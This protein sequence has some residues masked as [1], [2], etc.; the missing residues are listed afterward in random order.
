MANHEDQSQDS[1]NLSW[2]HSV[3]YHVDIDEPDANSP[4]GDHAAESPETS[5]QEPATTYNGVPRNVL[6]NAQPLLEDEIRLL[7]LEKGTHEIPLTGSLRIV[8]L[9]DYPEYE[10]LS[11]TWEDFDAVQPSE[12]NIQDEVHPALFLANTASYLDLTPNCAKALYSVRKTTAD[13]TIWVDSI[14][15]NQDDPEERSRQVDLMNEIYARAFKVLVYLGRDTNEDQSSSSIAMKLLSQPDRLQ[16]FDQLQQRETTSLKRLFER[17]YFRRMWIVQEVTLAKTL[18]LHCGRDTSYVSKFA[19][20]PLETILGSRVTPPWLRHSKQTASQPRKRQEMSQAEQIFGLI[21]DTSQCDCKDDRD[22]IFALFSLLNAKDEERLKADYNLSTTQVYSGLAAYLATSG[23]LWAMLMLAPRLA[24]N[25]CPG[26]PSWVPDWSSLGNYGQQAPSLLKSIVSSSLSLG[27]ETM[28]RIHNSGIIAVS[29]IHLGS[30]TYTGHSCDYPFQTAAMNEN[31]RLTTGLFAKKRG[32]DGSKKSQGHVSIWTLANLDRKK[33]LDSW[34][35]H[36]NFVTRCEQPRETQHLAFMLLDYSTVLILRYHNRF[37]DPYTLVEAGKPLIGVVP[38]QGWKGPFETSPRFDLQLL[39]R[40]TRGYDPWDT[41]FWLQEKWPGLSRFPQLWS[42]DP[43]ATSAKL[44]LR[45]IQEIRQIDM[46]E[47]YLLHRWQEHSHTVIGILKDQARLR[48]LIEQVIS[49]RDE[50]YAQREV[51]A[52]LDQGWSLYHFLG[53]FV[54]E[55]SKGENM[56]WH[57]MQLQGALSPDDFDLLSQVM[58]WAKVTRQVLR[59]LSREQRTVSHWSELL[60]DK[61]LYLWASNIADYQPSNGSDD[62]RGPHWTL[63]LLK[64]MFCALNEDHV[65]H[66]FEFSQEFVLTP[67]DICLM[68][69]EPANRRMWTWRKLN[70]VVGQMISILGHIKSDVN[71]VKYRLSY[72]PQ[73]FVEVAACQLFAAHGIDVRKKDFTRIRIR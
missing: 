50:D 18:E 37:G 61:D 56:V 10:P 30:V 60:M 69:I 58:E 67:Q 55:P 66:Q 14:C 70:R 42:L 12:G 27:P 45:A 62:R 7:D 36:L 63:L 16:Q 17:P 24:S 35:C 28:L 47:L 59:L 41:D 6:R 64:R 3:R 40:I 52:G 26:L 34:E 25:R 15:V 2:P 5:R 9:S 32:L 65:C 73:D 21:F 19:G 13:R 8:R 23:L 43:S 46:N 39:R 33:S 71:R 49:L 72:L 1:L 48:Y 38:P 31:Q 22:R 20:R 51:A 68:R 53:L 11:Y 4:R 54:M 57:D 29:G 44:T